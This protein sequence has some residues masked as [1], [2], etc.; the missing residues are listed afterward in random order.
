M[1][2]DHLRQHIPDPGHR[3]PGGRRH[4]LQHGLPIQCTRPA[5]AGGQLRQGAPHGLPLPSG[6]SRIH[7]LPRPREGCT[8]LQG[9]LRRL[10]VLHSGRDGRIHLPMETEDYRSAGNCRFE[11]S[12]D[13]ERPVLRRDEIRGEI[14]TKA[15]ELRQRR[16]QSTSGGVRDG[17]GHR[18]CESDPAVAEDRGGPQSSAVRRQLG[19]A[20][21]SAAGARLR[22]HRRHQ[23]TSRHVLPRRR[24]ALLRRRG[25]RSYESEDAL[26]EVL[27]AAPRHHHCD[28]RKQGGHGG[29]HWRPR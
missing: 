1:G 17:G 21:Q 19:A 10:A 15:G 14:V 8:Q 28:E 18:G 23:P 13:Y 3:G 6:E 22:F 5:G 11:E 27:H 25:G 29:G 24:A 2:L 16:E 20:G 12:R 4:H 26:A 7:H 9:S